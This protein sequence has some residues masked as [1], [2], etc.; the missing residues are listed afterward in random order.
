MQL[1]NYSVNIFKSFFFN[2]GPRRQ[3]EDKCGE[4]SS[5][6]RN[7]YRKNQSGLRGFKSSL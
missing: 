4:H 2:Y 5:Q 6:M 1:E 7:K 3:N